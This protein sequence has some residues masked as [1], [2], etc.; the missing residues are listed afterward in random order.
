MKEKI[1]PGLP[2]LRRGNEGEADAMKNRT[3]NGASP[4]E[5]AIGTKA[6]NKTFLIFAY[7]CC[8][9]KNVNYVSEF[10]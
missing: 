7:I 9:K 8:P 1:K 6:G 2:L 4:S 5:D 10:K 3:L